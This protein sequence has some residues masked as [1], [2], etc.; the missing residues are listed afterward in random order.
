MTFLHYLEV[1]EGIEAWSLTEQVMVAKQVTRGRED[2][3]S[4][5]DLMQMKPYKLQP[6]ERKD[7]SQW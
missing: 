2:L 3:A 7:G 4:K 6:S 1:A 5:G